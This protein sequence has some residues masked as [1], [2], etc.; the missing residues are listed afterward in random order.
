MKP[1]RVPHNFCGLPER[2]SSWRTARAVVI[3]VPY[4]LTSTYVAG[5]R[6]GPAAIIAASTHMET[7]DEELGVET[8]RIGIHT[9][10]PLETEASTPA[11]MIAAVES[12]VGG[13][14][15][16][17]KLPVVLGGEHS[18]T[19]GALR[20]LKKR[21]RRL[22][23]L[24]FDAHADLR[25]SY[26]GTPFSHACAGR[27]ALEAGTLVQVGIRSLSAEEARFRRGAAGLRT[28]FAADLVARRTDPREIVAC[29]GDPVYITVDLDV[30][31]PSVVPA[32]GTPEPGGL[33]WYDVI[34]ILREACAA[35]RV[36][37][38]DVVELCPMP[39]GVAS[40]FLAAKLVYRLLG[41]IFFGRRTPP[42]ARRSRRR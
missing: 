17:G 29:L 39:P 9:Q 1:D 7:Y 4:D 16:A 8:F 42:G 40:D 11:R 5:S 38:F 34:G 30:F 6:N 28:F 20:A 10:D 26:Q 35:R 15:A 31:D 37:G 41:Y 19:A 23:V 14:A 36:V 12:A 21:H 13:V 32:T 18:V 27:R 33:G 24:Q 3:P 2:S 22:S 25:D